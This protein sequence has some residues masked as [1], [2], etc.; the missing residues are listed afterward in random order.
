MRIDFVGHASLLFSAGPIKLLTDPWWEGPAY[1]GQWFPYPFPV[2]EKFDLSTLTALYLSHG[3]EDHMHAPTLAR[4]DKRPLVTM[5]RWYD[6]G[7]ADMVRELGFRRVEEIPSGG[8]FTLRMGGHSLQLTVLTYL[9]DS[10]LVVDDGHQVVVN[11][12]DALHCSRDEVIDEYCRIL[13]SRFPRIDDLF[14]GFGGA[15]YFPNCFRVPGKDDQAVAERRE[16]MFLQKFARVVQ[17]LRQRRAYPFAAHFVLPDERNWWISEQRLRQPPVAETLARLCQGTVTAVHHLHPGDSVDEGTIHHS[18]PS[19]PPPDDV[20]QKVLERHP[21]PARPARLERPQFVSLLTRVEAVARTNLARV[22]TKELHGAI[23]LW[24]YPDELMVIRARE[25]RLSLAAERAG[26]DL[27]PVIL[28]T[29]SDTLEA[30]IGEPFGRDQICIGYGGLMR[31]SSR[32]AVRA[33]LHERLLDLI[34]PLPS[35]KDRIRRDPLRCALYLAR[36]PGARLAL[37]LRLTPFGRKPSPV[38]SLEAW[39]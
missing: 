10:I 33:N 34:A 23:R 11:A 1:H 36:D 12:N 38:Y 8:S 39:T 20:R 24:D 15:S 4:L 29:R 16:A 21:P 13:V 26:K 14:C 22:G 32:E 31:V 5:P 18:E 6:S 3:H 17:R 35:W 7:N 9:G 2:P 28:E 19:A 27:P 37:K 30:A 25:G